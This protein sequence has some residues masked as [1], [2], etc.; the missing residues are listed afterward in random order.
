[1][2]I[3]HVTCLHTDLLSRK[4]RAAVWT[5]QIWSNTKCHAAEGHQYWT[6]M[7]NSVLIEKLQ[8]VAEYTWRHLF[9]PEAS[10]GRLAGGILLNEWLQAMSD[11]AGKVTECSA[12]W[13]KPG[14]CKGVLSCSCNEVAPKMSHLR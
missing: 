12:L 7:R 9:P 2:G 10:A 1:M 4:L 13:D 5:V 6:R 8:P 3:L 14:I 11:A